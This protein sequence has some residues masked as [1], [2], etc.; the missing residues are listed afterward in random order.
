MQISS[1]TVEIIVEACLGVNLASWGGGCS[2]LTYKYKRAAP[3]TP[4]SGGGRVPPP[5]MCGP[6]RLDLSFGG[7]KSFMLARCSPLAH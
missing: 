2:S 1:I 7:K 6:L 5:K 3:A 4:A